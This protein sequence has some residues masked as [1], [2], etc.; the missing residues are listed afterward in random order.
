MRVAIL[1]LGI[2]GET[3]ARNLIADGVAVRPWN[4][5]PK[6]I[7]GFVADAAAAARDADVVIIVV[8]DPPAVD[9]VLSRIEPALRSGQVVVQSSTISADWTHRFAARVAARGA[10]YLDAPFT[11]SKLAAQARETVYYV[12]GEADVIE[13]ARPVLS[14]LAKAIVPVGA[15]GTAS[16]VKLAMNINIALVAGALAE[17]LSFARAAGV[18]DDVFFA[19]LKLNASRSGVAD[20]K[21]PKLRSGDFSPQ[22][23]LKHMDKDLRLAL[24]GAGSAALPLLR[25]LKELSDQGMRAG[26]SDDDFS[27][28]IR[29]AGRG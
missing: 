16:S 13:R 12:G 20:L 1:G 9:A 28:L 10:A 29:L 2:I 22:F 21:E 17:S 26:W 19:A 14:R 8:A 11:G 6:D 5:T 24:E 15:I 7:P 4:R 18:S 25:R 27:C 3:W 23:S